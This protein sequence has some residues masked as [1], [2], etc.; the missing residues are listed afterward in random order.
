[1][2]NAE[3]V[4]GVTYRWGESMI[5]AALVPEEGMNES[6][7]VHDGGIIR[8][9]IWHYPSRTE[10]LICHTPV[11]GWALGLN[12]AQMNRDFDYFGTV[13]NQLA[14]LRQAGYLDVDPGDVATLPVMAS[15][16]NSSFSVEHRSRSYLAA[17]CAQCHQPGGSAQGHWDARFSTALSEAGII[18]GAL[19][20]NL[21]NASNRVM[22]PGSLENSMLLRR[23]SQLGSGHMP[24]L[25]T[26][27]LNYQAIDLLSAWITNGLSSLSVSLALGGHIH[28]S[29]PGVAG[30]MYRVERSIDLEQWETVAAVAATPSG[31]VDYTEQVP[32]LTIAHFYRIAWP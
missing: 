3:G 23:I 10:C 18:D 19:A 21:G 2:R 14:A 16:T 30:R 29:C 22:R 28:I 12:S 13:T 32:G 1:V 11:A 27:E 4:Y 25:A 20:D 17:N 9:Q 15:A 8:T 5:N 24:P 31:I 6:F 26:S 7:L